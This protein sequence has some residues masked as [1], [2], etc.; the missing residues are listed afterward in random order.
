MPACKH[1]HLDGDRTMVEI[2]PFLHSL[3]HDDFRLEDYQFRLNRWLGHAEAISNW[4]LEGGLHEN[5]VEKFKV[6]T[7]VMQNP[8]TIFHAVKNFVVINGSRGFY[9]EFI[10]APQCHIF[11]DACCPK[12]TLTK[13]DV[14]NIVIKGIQAGEKQLKKEKINATFNAWWGIGREMSEE[15]AESSIREMLECDPKYV[16]GPSIVCHEPSGRPEKFIKACQLAKSEGRKTACH[17]E[18]VKD[19]KPHEKDTPEKIRMNFQ[20]DLSQL[21]KNLRTAIFD[22]QIDQLDHGFGLAESPEL[23]KAVVDGEIIVTVCPGS[24][25]TTGV[26]DDIKMMKIREMLDAGI[27]VCWDVDDDICMPIYDGLE[28]MYR[29]A[30]A[31]PP[32]TEN[33]DRLKTDLRQL[34][35]NADRCLFNDRRTRPL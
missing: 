7:G 12:G 6:T 35:I 11:G 34:E 13:K 24:L 20:E 18:W 23:M 15:E 25:L 28:P 8:F 33:L 14:M 29:D 16:L 1:R 26:I 19:R 2:M 4:F 22:L 27:L 3:T 30:Y 31:K 5:L 9:G 32:S 17:V 21:T 10:M